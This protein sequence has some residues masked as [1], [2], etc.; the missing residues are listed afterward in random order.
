M[1]PRLADLRGL[2][3]DRDPLLAMLRVER[4]HLPRLRKAV[5]EPM[6]T[7]IP[8]LGI[9]T[10]LFVYLAAFVLTALVL[11]LLERAFRR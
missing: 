10:L 4:P 1:R 2:H 8:V 7:E 6:S 9:R 3:P 11:V 5:R